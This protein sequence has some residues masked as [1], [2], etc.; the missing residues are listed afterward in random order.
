MLFGICLE[1][2]TFLRGG[3]EW[4]RI[5]GVTLWHLIFFGIVKIKSP[6][7]K[8]IKQHK[9]F[10]AGAIAKK[11]GVG[12]VIMCHVF[13]HQYTLFCTLNRTVWAQNPGDIITSFL[14]L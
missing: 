10:L 13:H 12:G 3:V 14:Q 9:H 1:F 8:Y 7:L 6:G 5:W 4:V 2:T 11:A